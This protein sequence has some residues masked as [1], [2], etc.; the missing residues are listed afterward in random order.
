MNTYVADVIRKYKNKGLLIDTNIAILYLIG[1]FDLSEIRRHGRTSGYH[2][3][4]FLRLSKFIDYFGVR[5]T[6]PHVLTEV[7]DLLGNKYE[8]H[9]VLQG[10]IARAEEVHETSDFLSGQATFIKIGLADTAIVVAAAKKDY[11]VLTDDGPLQHFLSTAK[12]D[13]VTLDQIIAI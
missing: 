11:L 5:V 2:E 7:S 3:D 8:L 6:T 4:D 12:I 13:F 1:S 9:R 10:F